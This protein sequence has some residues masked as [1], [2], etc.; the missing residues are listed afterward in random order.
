M[1]VCK[2]G[3]CIILPSPNGEEAGSNSSLNQTII[4]NPPGHSY[5]LDSGP[6][7]PPIKN[8]PYTRMLGCGYWT[9]FTVELSLQ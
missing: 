8:L 3:D 9:E 6:N 5:G 1:Y 2:S 7:H 4:H